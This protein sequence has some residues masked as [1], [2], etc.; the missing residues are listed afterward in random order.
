[1]IIH[2]RFQKDYSE[3]GIEVQLNFDIENDVVNIFAIHIKATFE[4]NLPTNPTLTQ[5]NG[6]NLLVGHYIT[7]EGNNTTSV[8]TENKYAD[9]IVQ[10]IM[11]LKDILKNRL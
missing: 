1:M 8:I 9:D 10:E 7:R 3:G 2:K 5:L 6:K 4:T 11:E